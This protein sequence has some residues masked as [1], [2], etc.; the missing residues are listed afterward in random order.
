MVNAFRMTKKRQVKIKLWYC[1]ETQRKANG[2][3]DR[4]EEKGR[5]L[6][7]KL[8]LIFRYFFDSIISPRSRPNGRLGDGTSR[9]KIRGIND[10]S[11]T[12]D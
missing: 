4:L 1:F 12:R 3:R 2:R 11:K 9:S 5:A 8:F 10:E 6:Q 7:S